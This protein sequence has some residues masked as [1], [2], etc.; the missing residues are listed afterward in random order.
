MRAR[1]RCSGLAVEHA[2]GP[3]HSCGRSSRHR[4]C[5]PASRILPFLHADNDYPVDAARQ[6]LEIHSQPNPGSEEFRPVWP[7]DG[8]HIAF[9]SDRDG[10][11]E[12]C[13]MDADSSNQTRL[14]PNTADNYWP[15]WGPYNLLGAPPNRTG[16]QGGN[17]GW[18]T[19]HIARRATLGWVCAPL[20]R[21]KP[22]C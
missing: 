16:G 5:R 3:I 6:L 8:F 4:T 18:S 7:P 15:A 21:C 2:R 14:T 12:I 19:P 20:T 9:T 10:N 17:H 11:L 1:L 13:I 22:Q